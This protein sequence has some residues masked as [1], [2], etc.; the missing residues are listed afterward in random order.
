D[1]APEFRVAQ[2]VDNG[3]SQVG[4]WQLA[5][6]HQNLRERML[7]KPATW[8]SGDPV[9]VTVRFARDSPNRP[10][11]KALTAAAGAFPIAVGDRTVRWDFGGDWAL[12]RLVRA[13]RSVAAGLS[14]SRE[15]SPIV[16]GFQIPVERDPTRP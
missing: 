9:S 11:A 3:G 8:T 2:D 14:A 4:E 5:I 1:V 7:S 16:L 10:V 15:L 6:A 13:G 12:I